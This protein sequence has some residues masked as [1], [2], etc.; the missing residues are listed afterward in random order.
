MTR[1]CLSISIAI[2]ITISMDASDDESRRS[3]IDQKVRLPLYVYPV[4]VHSEWVDF[5]SGRGR[6]ELETAG[7]AAH[8]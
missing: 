5:G 7:G 4:S 2:P 1:S 3:T 6:S 8:R